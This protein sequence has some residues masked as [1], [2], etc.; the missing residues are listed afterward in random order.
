MREGDGAVSREL[1]A[2]SGSFVTFAYDGKND[3]YET[4]RFVVASRYLWGADEL[5]ELYESTRAS[6]LV[7]P[8]E[9]GHDD[10]AWG[11]WHLVKVKEDTDF[12]IIERRIE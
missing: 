3:N 12:F 6:F 1:E 5:K 8:G 7:A 10:D 4:V 11:S 9:K 2:C